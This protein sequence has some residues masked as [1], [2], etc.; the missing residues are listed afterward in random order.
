ML[1]A[2]SW[3]FLTTWITPL[4]SINRIRIHVT[5]YNLLF[6]IRYCSYLLIFIYT[7]M[8]VVFHLH[9]SISTYVYSRTPPHWMYFMVCNILVWLLSSWYTTRT[10]TYDVSPPR[11]FISTIF[12]HVWFIYYDISTIRHNASFSLTSHLNLVKIC[13]SPS[14]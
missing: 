9:V 12:S 13:V 2:I 14:F 8:L 3:N 6:E 4:S 7:C 10:P 1:V 5:C 11:Y